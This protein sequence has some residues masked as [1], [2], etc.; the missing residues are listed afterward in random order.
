MTLLTLAIGIGANTAVFSVVHGV[1]MKP[2]A[3]PDPDRLVGLWLT[4]SGMNIPQLNAT[5]SLFHL[6]KEEG[7]AFEELGLWNPGST[8][9]TGLAEPEE[10]PTLFVTQGVLPLLGVQ[11][12]AGRSWT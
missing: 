1:L 4:A 9:V 8:T 6:Y 5:Q 3:F 7:R 2:L 11:P 12:A 10:V